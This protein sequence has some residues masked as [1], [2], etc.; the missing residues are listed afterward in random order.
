LTTPSRRGAWA[1]VTHMAR[2]E[3]RR[4]GAGAAGAAG[5]RDG[6]IDEFS[7]AVQGTLPRGNSLGNMGLFKADCGYPQRRGRASKKTT[8]KLLSSNRIEDDATPE[9]RARTP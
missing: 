6:V 7:P 4:P 5:G 1:E 3:R 2:L 9:K 8:V